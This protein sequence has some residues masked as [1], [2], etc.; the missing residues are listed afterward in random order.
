MINKAEIEKEILKFLDWILIAEDTREKL[1]N[2]LKE[3]RTDI[4]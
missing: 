1:K 4:L 2:K 3:Y